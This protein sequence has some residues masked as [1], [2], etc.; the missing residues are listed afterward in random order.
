[1]QGRLSK[2]TELGPEPQTALALGPTPAHAWEGGSLLK[3]AER[4][5]LLTIAVGVEKP[6]SLPQWAFFFFFSSRKGLGPTVK[7]AKCEGCST[8]HALLFCDLSQSHIP[9]QCQSEAIR[10]SMHKPARVR[11]AQY[12]KQGL[13]P[14]PP[15]AHALMQVTFKCT[16]SKPQPVPDAPE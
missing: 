6:W 2:A 4:C 11:A 7:G 16:Q 13:Y 5:G 14:P 10:L 8:R 15:R 1:M 3:P 9:T 12:R